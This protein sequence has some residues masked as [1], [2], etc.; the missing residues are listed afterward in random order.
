MDACR[1]RTEIL[2]VQSLNVHPATEIERQSAKINTSD[3]LLSELRSQLRH[4]LIS[5]LHTPLANTDHR[6]QLA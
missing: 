1:S 5:L 6:F 4:A 3:F 2:S